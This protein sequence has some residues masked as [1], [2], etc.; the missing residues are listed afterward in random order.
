MQVAELV[1]LQVRRAED[2]GVR[3]VRGPP[4]RRGRRRPSTARSGRL[5]QRALDVLVPNAIAAGA[6]ELGFAITTDDGGVVVE[7]E[8]DAGGFH[9]AAVPAG[10]ALDGLQRDLGR[11]ACHWRAP[12]G[13]A[14]S[15]WSSAGRRW[16]RRWRAATARRRCDDPAA[17]RRRL[18]PGPH[19]AARRRSPC[20]LGWTRGHRAPARRRGRRRWP[21]RSP[22]TWP[23]STWPTPT[24]TLN[25]LDVLLTLYE[26]APRCRPVVYTQGD[27]SVADMLRDAWDAFDLATAISKSRSIPSV[28][29]DLQ[30]RRDARLGPG[31]PVPPAAAARAT[32]SP[33][34][35]IEGYGRLVGHAGHAKLWRALIELDEEPSY[36]DLAEHTGL[37]L[38]SVRNYRGELLD[39]LA[40]HYLDRPRMRQMQLF[41][42]RCRPLLEPHIRRK[43]DV[44]R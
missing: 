18:R 35:S 43:L 26:Q 39:D 16:P 11:A 22:S 7:V 24:R 1:Q 33:W 44:H 25:G 37:S 10:R 8:D 41:A 40:L 5:I 4:V 17:H 28:L 19:A 21:S 32:R 15:A 36:K 30:R 3:V 34:R 6:R 31:R 29:R 13:A 12:T 27:P 20:E 23:W 9:L 38:P 2:Q 42:K 14:S